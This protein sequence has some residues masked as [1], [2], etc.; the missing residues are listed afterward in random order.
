MDESESVAGRPAHR[1]HV[2]DRPGR[3]VVAR[4]DGT[5]ITQLTNDT[6]RDRTP[7]WSP[8]GETLAFHSDRGGWYS[9]WTIQADGRGLARVMDPGSDGYILPVWSP[10]GQR[11]AASMAHE[12][13]LAITTRTA[14]GWGTPELVKAAPAGFAAISWSADGQWILGM[15]L[16][17]NWEIASVHVTSGEYRVFASDRGGWPIW[18]PDSRR[19]IFNASG[20]LKLG[21]FSAPSAPSRALG[22][23]TAVAAF[24]LDA[25]GRTLVTATRRDEAD[26][27]LMEA[28]GGR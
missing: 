1:V 19:F 12:H 5:G 15:N 28:R 20:R 13:R 10:D 4:A 26:L 17:R 18:L 8:D 2:D 11:L 24:D 6:A 22:D 27:W 25:G 21:D 3:S 7:K 16:V 23:F 14:S 9:I